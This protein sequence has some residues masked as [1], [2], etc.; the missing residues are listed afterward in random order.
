M[1]VDSR[2]P[3]ILFAS[4]VPFSI[5]FDILTNKGIIVPIAD[6]QYNWTKSKTSLAEYFKWIGKN[7]PYVPGGF[8]APIEYMFLIKKEPIKR[9]DLRRLAGKNGNGAKPD[10]SRD[11]ME[12]KKIVLQ[13]RKE[14]GEQLK[15]FR[16]I[17]KLIRKAEYGNPEI[18]KATLEKIKEILT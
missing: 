6:N 7:A 2:N 12:I 3:L 9:G 10:E 18:I 14:T 13:Y 8:W 4:F 16:A 15:T 1:N 11:F 17:R 5:D